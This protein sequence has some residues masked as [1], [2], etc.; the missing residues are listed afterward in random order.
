MKNV[1]VI[2]EAMRVLGI[3]VSLIDPTRLTSSFQRRHISLLQPR[4]NGLENFLCIRNFDPVI[5]YN[6]HLLAI[7]GI[8]DQQHGLVIDDRDQQ[9]SNALVVVSQ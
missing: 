6:F 3:A 9:G 1:S 5:S 7:G 2:T 4:P 8:Q